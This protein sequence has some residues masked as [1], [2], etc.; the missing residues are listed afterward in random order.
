[1]DRFIRQLAAGNLRPY[2]N[3]CSCCGAPAQL[4]EIGAGVAIFVSRRAAVVLSNPHSPGKFRVNGVVRNFDAWYQA[5]D[6]KPGDQLYL[7]PE[8]RIRVW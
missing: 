1:M 8:A 4:R 2:S 3:S 5:F 7:A 6:V